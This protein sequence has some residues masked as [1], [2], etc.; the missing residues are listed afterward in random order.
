MNGQLVRAVSMGAAMFIANRSHYA[1]YWQIAILVAVTI[2]IHG[3]A[4][5]I[6]FVLAPRNK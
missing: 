5:A 3:T 2:V 1:W 6:Q 4:L